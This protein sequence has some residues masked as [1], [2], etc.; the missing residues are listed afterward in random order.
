MH[1]FGGFTKLNTPANNLKDVFC[2]NILSSQLKFGHGQNE[3][4]YEM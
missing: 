1:I 4:Q 3:A 2:G